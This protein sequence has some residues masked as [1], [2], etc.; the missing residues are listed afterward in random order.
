[1]S[2]DAKQDDT[3]CL[4]HVIFHK[5]QQQKAVKSKLSTLIVTPVHL[6]CNFNHVLVVVVIRW[7][8]FSF[9]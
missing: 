8:G 3:N 2:T 6:H 5:P 1:M 7:F 9:S 4:H